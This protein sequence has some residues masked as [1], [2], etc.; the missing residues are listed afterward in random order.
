MS[1][2]PDYRDDPEAYEIEQRSRPDEMMMIEHACQ[3]AAQWL[4]GC[5]DA[6]ALDLCCGTGLSTRCLAEHPHISGVTGVDNCGSYLD[7]A[8]KVLADCRVVPIL[9]KDDSVTVSSKRLGR[10]SWDLVMMASAYHHI[11]NSRKIRFL[12]RVRNLIGRTGCA[13]MA[14]NVLPEYAEGKPEEYKR[15]VE[16][17][18]HEVLRTARASNPNLPARVES[19]IERVA[20]YGYDGDYEYKVS[21][22]ILR[23]HLNLVG[24]SIADETCVWP[25]NGELGAEAGNFVFVLKA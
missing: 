20:Q 12:R 17:F 22:G 13:I 6:Y 2:L 4:D 1:S 23:Q 16:V 7:Y 21:M 10:D 18:Y 9:L 5:V 14:E 19:L 3:R 24:L 15:A 11:E 25:I 8:R